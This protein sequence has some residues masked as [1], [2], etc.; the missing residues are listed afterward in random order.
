[1]IW[2]GGFLLTILGAVFGRIFSQ[3]EVVLAEKRR[4]YET[5]LV[6]CPSPTE[7]YIDWTEEVEADRQKRLSKVQGPLLL[8]GSVT[9]ALAFE[10]YLERFCEA[11][12]LLTSQSPALHPAYKA[13]A[14]AQNDMVL[15]MRR[16]ALSWSFFGYFGKSRLPDNALE[17]AK[18][19]NLE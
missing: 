9:V 16:D 18:Q 11:D 10:I 17:S 3:S 14:K 2:L 7:A 6:E 8:Y 15:E 4:V 19:K 12:Q 1:V 13:L 5:F